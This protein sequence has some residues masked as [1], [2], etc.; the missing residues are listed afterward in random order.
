VVQDKQRLPLPPATNGQ[1]SETSQKRPEKLT[2]QGAMLEKALLA[3][4]DALLDHAQE[5]DE[6][7]QR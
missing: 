1:S 3:A 7:D 4:A 2:Q 6:W 5:L